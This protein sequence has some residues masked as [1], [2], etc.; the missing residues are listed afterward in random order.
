MAEYND[1]FTL[2]GKLKPSNF[3]V[4][5]AKVEAADSL[6]REA[7]HGDRIAAGK[8]AEAFSS[9]DLPFNVAHLITAVTIP[10][11]EEASRTWSQVAGVRT[12]DDFGPVRLQSLYSSVTGSAVHANGGLVTVPEHT[13]YPHITVAGKEAF[14][15][16]LAKHG[17]RFTWSWE[18]GVN[19]VAGFFEQIPGELLSLALDTEEREVY[20]A[21]VNGTTQELAGNDLPDG[22]AVA[23]NAAISPAAIWSAIIQLQNVEVNGRKVGRASGYN[24][25]VPT[26][27]GDFINYAL[28]REVISVQDGLITYGPGDTSALNNVTVVETNYLTGT[29]W[30]VLP[31]PGSIRRPVLELL[32]LRGYERPELRVQ[33]NAGNYVGGGVVAPFE[34]DFEADEIA[35]RVRFV[36]GGV[37]WDDVYSVKS[38]GTGQA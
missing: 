35:M 23:P 5:R 36:A 17:G 32:R 34:G 30:I 20:E 27:T 22:T 6:L 11:F 7:M 10:Q 19:D 25:V 33:A 13:P 29:N 12:V 31:K 26:G 9:T 24:V 15:A 4:T 2:D 16:K 18:S 28:R 21:L 8:L 14:Y 38:D 37:L 1:E 3:K